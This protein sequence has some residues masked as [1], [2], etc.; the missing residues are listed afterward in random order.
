MNMH[1]TTVIRWAWHCGV[2]LVL[3]VAATAAERRPNIVLIVSDDH[4]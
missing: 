1:V 3:I 4:G 2:A